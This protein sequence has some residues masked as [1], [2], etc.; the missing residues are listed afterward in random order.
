VTGEVLSGLAA[1]RACGFH[2]RRWADD[3]LACCRTTL[4]L[5]PAT[6]VSPL[7]ADADDLQRTASS[8]ACQDALAE[9][10]DQVADRAVIARV[11]RIEL[12]KNL[13]RGFQAY[14]DLLEHEP[15]WRQRVV[16]IASCYPSRTGV[17]AYIEYQREVEA[18]VDRIN[19]R[20]AT[21]DWTPIV[22]DTRD[23]YPRSVAVLRRA[24]V[25]LVNPIRDGLNLVA[26]EAA[27]VNERDVVVCLSTEAGVWDELSDAV[28]QVQPF[29]VAG[30]ADA[31]AKALGMHAG[32]RRSRAAM[33]RRL[34]VARRPADWL[35]DQLA[36][37]GG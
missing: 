7:P 25:L 37:A 21:P 35:A 22:Y 23:D 3:F 28:V 33:L 20:W 10:E 13:L 34:A 16:F 6:F 15:G 11:D 2:S 17:P 18:L 31:L 32:E 1:H 14:D 4:A 12:S 19:E 29:D 30:T 36:A 24:D 26:K 5:A 27:I 9:I 8:P